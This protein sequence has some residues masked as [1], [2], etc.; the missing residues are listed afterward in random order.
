MNSINSR[1][2]SI[3]AG[4]LCV[5]PA[6]WTLDADAMV[7]GYARESHGSKTQSNQ[8]KRENKQ[9]C[10]VAL[11]K[12]AYELAEK[13]AHENDRTSKI[14]I[15]PI[16]FEMV[17]EKELPLS[18]ARVS[19]VAHNTRG[20]N[21]YAHIK[22]SR[23]LLRASAALQARNIL[24]E[25]AH[26]YDQHLWDTFNTGKYD[27][28]FECYPFLKN[29]MQACKRKWSK[30]APEMIASEWYADWQSVQW[31]KKY[32]PER[33]ARLKRELLAEV[34]YEKHQGLTSLIY[35]PSEMLLKWL[36]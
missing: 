21:H 30:A 22:L 32:V 23:G 9:L 20:R 31:L 25:L 17:S 6:L 12:K 33:G 19:L 11:L 28:S 5:S 35:P 16:T 7:S 27:S 3:L 1:F 29:D 24:H 34:E 8:S 26:A 14:Q 15:F 2:L 18:A 36:S 4:V 13:I 10:E